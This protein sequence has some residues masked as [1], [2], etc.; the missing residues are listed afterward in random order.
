M[1]CS[2]HANIHF[3]CVAMYNTCAHSIIRV[4][5]RNICLGGKLRRGHSPRRQTSGGSGGSP[6]G[7]MLNFR[8]P[9]TQFRVIKGSL[10]LKNILHTITSLLILALLYYLIIVVVLYKHCTQ[11]ATLGG[12]A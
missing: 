5:S 7:K 11:H 8:S 3:D 4:L 10:F 12:E 1:L 9:E 2:V 6:P